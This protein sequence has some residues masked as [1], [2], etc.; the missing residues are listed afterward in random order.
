MG[1]I[2]LLHRNVVVICLK[3][4]GAVAVL[5]VL[6]RR[7]RVLAGDVGLVVAVV[8][9]VGGRLLRGCQQRLWGEVGAAQQILEHHIGI[10]S[11]RT[12]SGCCGRRCF[13]HR[14]QH[15]FSAKTAQMIVVWAVYASCV[16]LHFVLKMV[17]VAV[18]L[19]TTVVQLAV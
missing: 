5:L 18:P 15:C 2:I 17:R 13:Q 10:G 12:G 7:E 3:I 9:T 19:C 14:C 1:F 6:N 16:I 11:W 8:V 4:E